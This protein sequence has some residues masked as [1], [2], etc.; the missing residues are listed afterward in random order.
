MTIP[1]AQTSVAFVAFFIGKGASK[2]GSETWK[3]SDAIQRILPAISFV[4]VGFPGRDNIIWRESPK[5]ARSGLPLGE[6]RTFA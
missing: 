1:N 4:V 6:T 2:S 3:N 5:S